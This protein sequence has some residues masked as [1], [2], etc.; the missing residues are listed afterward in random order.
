MTWIAVGILGAAGTLLRYLVMAGMPTTTFPWGVFLVNIAG[1]A[2]GG[3]VLGYPGISEK[4]TNEW[5]T[6]LTVG[7]L[8]G[9]TTFS[10][11]SMDTVR[12]WQGG[13]AAAALLNVLMNNVFA[14][15]ACY[16]GWKISSQL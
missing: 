14:L 7:L 1:S 10:A 8:G 16:V 9:L 6:A 5:L 4:I 2:V 13:F 15:F 11:M 12:L 3:F